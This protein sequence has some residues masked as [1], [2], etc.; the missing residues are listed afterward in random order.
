LFVG[1]NIG[2]VLATAMGM[3]TYHRGIGEFNDCR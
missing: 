1:V 2:G 3:R